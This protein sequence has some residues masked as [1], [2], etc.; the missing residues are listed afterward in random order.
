MN[1]D[2][3][4][5]VG[6]AVVE[7]AEAKVDIKLPRTR[8]VP[9]TDNLKCNGYFNIPPE[10]CVGMSKPQGQWLRIFVHEYCHFRQWV[11]KEP[12]FMTFDHTNGMGEFDEWLDH[13]KELTKTQVLACTRAC[14]ELELDCEKRVVEMINLFHLPID[15][16]NYIKRA[17]AYVLFYNYVMK[18]RYW[19]GKISPY[20]PKEVLDTVPAYWMVS[21][22]TMSSEYEDAITRYVR[23]ADEKK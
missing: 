2:V 12:C 3:K 22:K 23:E 17:N 11:E 5:F 4:N 14:Q 21:Y 13:K 20:E 6:M 16:E 10:F 15:I 7:M 8:K 19:S 1:P 9:L 18:H